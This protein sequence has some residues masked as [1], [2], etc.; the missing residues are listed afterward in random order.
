[1]VFICNI[2]HATAAA[3]K[4]FP[5]FFSQMMEQE[6]MNLKLTTFVPFICFSPMKRSILLLFSWFYI[7]LPQ[8]ALISKY[9]FE[10]F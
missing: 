4:I 7:V 3:L 6:K 9:S 10:V 5:I 1:M 8:R 2:L